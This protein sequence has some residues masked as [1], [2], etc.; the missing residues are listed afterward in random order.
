MCAKMLELY[1]VPSW[2]YTA[3]TGIIV[4]CLKEMQVSV[5]VCVI[6]Y[7]P[8]FQSPFPEAIWVTVLSFKTPNGRK[9]L[10]ANHSVLYVLACGKCALFSTN[11]IHNSKYAR[12][13]EKQHNSVLQRK[14]LEENEYHYS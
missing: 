1:P 3:K 12:Y 14:G 2:L 5:Q 7:F 6:L 11:L 4:Y 8:R 9:C 10:D 13:L